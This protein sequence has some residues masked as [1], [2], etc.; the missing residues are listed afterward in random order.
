MIEQV[1]TKGKAREGAGR[2]AAVERA[3]VI[4]ENLQHLHRCLA[5]GLAKRAGIPGKEAIEWAT[6][7][8]EVLQEEVGGDRL[9]SK[10]IYIPAPD[11]RRRRNDRIIELMGPPPH[12][13]RRVREVAA[14]EKCHVS[15]VWRALNA[16]KDVALET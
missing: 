8:I 4:H 3:P 9:G 16:L 10:G 13:R 11:Y 14:M 7:C 12:S 6:A 15:T 5:I 2:A 1:A